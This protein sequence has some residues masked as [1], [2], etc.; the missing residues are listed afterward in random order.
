MHLLETSL[1]RYFSNKGFYVIFE[2]KS[3]LPKCFYVKLNG[4]FYIGKCFL[5][6]VTFPNYYTF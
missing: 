4:R 6:G 5:I 1:Y 3:L 2:F